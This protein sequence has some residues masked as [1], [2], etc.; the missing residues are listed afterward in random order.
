ML[1]TKG[2]IK[3]VRKRIENPVAETLSRKSTVII[4]SRMAA[5][6]FQTATVSPTREKIE[7]LAAKMKRQRL[8]RRNK[9]YCSDV[10][11][12]NLFLHCRN[13]QVIQFVIVDPGQIADRIARKDARASFGYFGR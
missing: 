13:V 5:S 1:V 2:G 11:L 9:N 6:S 3:R 10:L 12:Q 7:V 8:F 4:L